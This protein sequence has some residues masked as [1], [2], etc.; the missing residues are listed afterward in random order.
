MGSGAILR[1]VIAAADL[2]RDDWGV[3]ADIWSTT[4]FTELAREAR[5]CDRWNRLHPMEEARVPY[6]TQCF[7]GQP[8]PVI[9]A[10]D[11]IQLY[12]DKVRK[13]IPARYE[14]LGTDGF[15]RSD[16][17]AQLRKHFEV[18]AVH[19]V[20]A[21][22]KALADEGVIDVASVAEAIKK[23]AIDPEKINPLHA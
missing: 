5:G 1:E 21:A 8:G 23:Y 4:S 20:V 17:R 22:L 16:T 6:V 18:N 14:V 13:W 3:D 9:A 19:V 11:Y 7:K 15:G 12:A 10:T 2:L